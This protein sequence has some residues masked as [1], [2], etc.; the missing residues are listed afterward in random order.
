MSK[1]SPPEVWDFTSAEAYIKAGRNPERRPLKDGWNTELVKADSDLYKV[2]LRGEMIVAYTRADRILIYQENTEFVTL[3]RIQ[4]YALGTRYKLT[5][6]K[7]G[8]TLWEQTQRLAHAV[9]DDPVFA[10]GPLMTLPVML[11]LDDNRDIVLPGGKPTATPASREQVSKM[12][13]PI[14]KEWLAEYDKHLKAGIPAL[15]VCA[16]CV[17]AD[18][19]ICLGD[20]LNDPEH[21]FAHVLE[22]AYPADLVVNAVR[23]SVGSTTGY[24]ATTTSGDITYEEPRREE[25]KRILMRYMS[26]M[27][28]VRI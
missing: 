18:G 19:K 10:Y 1:A 15:P 17:S 21:L 16:M 26:N 13:R 27:L 12:M 22:P 23:V 7:D 2:M 24:L 4:R 3:D 9:G 20:V 25:V 5:K 8:V 28:R 11:E 14:L 6:G